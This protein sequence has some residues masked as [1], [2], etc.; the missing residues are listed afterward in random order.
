M[1][2]AAVPAFGGLAHAPTFSV[3]LHRIV[4]GLDPA[5]SANPI[6]GR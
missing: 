4:L 1:A 2:I 3:V 5:N 6:R